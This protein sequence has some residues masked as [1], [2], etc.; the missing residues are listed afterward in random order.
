MA[1]SN[2]FIT[3]VQNAVKYRIPREILDIE[4]KLA[5]IKSS[6]EQDERLLENLRIQ[7]QFGR[8]AV[9]S[10]EDSERLVSQ[11]LLMAFVIPEYDFV[12]ELGRKLIYL[13]WPKPQ[14]AFVRT[15]QKA[16]ESNDQLLGTRP[17]LIDG[18]QVP[19]TISSWIKDYES[20]PVEGPF[21]TSFDLVNYLTKSPNAARL[22]KPDRELLQKVLNVYDALEGRA[23]DL[24]DSYDLILSKNFED[25]NFFESIPGVD[26]REFLLKEDAQP[27]QP[28][29]LGVK[30]EGEDEVEL[31]VESEPETSE[32]NEVSGDN[33]FVERVKAAQSP[34]APKPVGQAT[35][36]P[37]TPQTPVVPGPPAH[38][39]PTPQPKS[40]PATPIMPGFEHLSKGIASGPVAKP[41][42]PAG[43]K[44]PVMPTPA[45]SK[46]AIP[47]APPAPKPAEHL[48]PAAPN[49]AQIRAELQ[50]RLKEEEAAAQKKIADKLEELKKRKS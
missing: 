13:E 47:V 22:A 31:S 45:E 21:H 3:S 12:D 17:L 2:D 19:Q 42:M 23:V 40:Q 50:K 15:I 14:Y 1:L 38:V 25:L 36:S 44:A 29:S 5:L 35:S 37:P 18:A 30:I 9:L 24:K 6:S 48:K 10:D 20:F 33:E 39:A 43:V 32:N 11:H 4:H 27:P 28:S 16:M 46:P 41:V 34:A 26:A 7:L 8:F 49:F